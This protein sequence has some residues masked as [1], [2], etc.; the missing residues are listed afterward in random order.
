VLA[1]KSS[2][3]I[4]WEEPEL[5]IRAI[6]TVADSFEGAVAASGSAASDSSGLAK[7]AKD[8]SQVLRD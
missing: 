5:V 3:W 2:H 7:S 4:M 8:A 6:Q 1:K